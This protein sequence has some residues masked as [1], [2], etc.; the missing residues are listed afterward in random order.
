MELSQSG[1]RE[2]RGVLKAIGLDQEEDTPSRRR[3][4]RST[5]LAILCLRLRSQIDQRGRANVEEPRRSRSA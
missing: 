3:L 5:W 2:V 4:W 1:E